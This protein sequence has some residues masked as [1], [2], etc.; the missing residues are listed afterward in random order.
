MPLP[1]TTRKEQLKLVNHFVSAHDLLCECPEPAKHCFNV[2][3]KQLKPEFTEQDKNQIKQCLGTATTAAVEE[4]AGL[5]PGDL[6]KLF[7]DDD[8]EED[9]NR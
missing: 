2:L 5:D 4:D 1:L 3:L 7:G 6:E 9:D 8:G